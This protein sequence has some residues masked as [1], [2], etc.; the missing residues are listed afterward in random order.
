MRR[1]IARL[2]HHYAI[3][4][5][6]EAVKCSRVVVEL[7]AE[8][9]DQLSARCHLVW[10]ELFANEC[11][12]D[13]SP[14][15]RFEQHFTSPQFFAQDLFLIHSDR[16][17]RDRVLCV[18]WLPL[19]RGGHSSR[20]YVAARLKLPTRMLQRAAVGERLLAHCACLF[21]IAPGRGCRV[22]P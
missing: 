2:N 13:L 19:A 16:C 3:K 17:I 9:N 8:H 1:F 7:V 14:R 20:T 22:S 6:I 11:A 18:R 15:H 10:C 5:R 21:D 4:R 12:C